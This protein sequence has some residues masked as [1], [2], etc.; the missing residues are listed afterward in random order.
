M[1]KIKKATKPIKAS[2]KT[3]AKGAEKKRKVP[4]TGGI[5]KTYLKS[6]NTCKVTLRLPEA[7]AASAGSVYVVGDFNG[8]DQRSLPM[9]KLKS[10]VHTI[11]LDLEP[12]REYQFRYLIDGER[13]ENDWFAD[14][15]VISPYGDSDNS[16]IIV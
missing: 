5:K 14:K 4:N 13:W 1:L 16:V 9:K 10:G 8:W 15:Y 11:T 12:G 3:T 7:A 6:R 2:R